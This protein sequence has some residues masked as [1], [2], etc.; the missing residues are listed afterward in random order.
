MKKMILLLLVVSSSVFAQQSEPAK[1]N[2]QNFVLIGSVEDQEKQYNEMLK[3]DP[4]DPAKPA[5]YEEYRAQLALGW[6]TKGNFDRYWYYKNTNPK[7]N[8][9]QLMYL[10][11]AMEHFLDENKHLA[12]LEKVSGGILKDFESGAIKDPIGRAQPIME[13]NAAVNAQLGNIAIAEKMLDQSSK[14]KES[15]R[16]MRYF[17]DT[18]SNYLNRYAIVMS[19]AGK[20]QIAFDTLTKAFRDADSNPAMVNTFRQVYKKVKGSE[21]GFEKYLKSLQDEAYQECYREVTQLYIASPK[22][23]MD[24]FFP[25]PAGKEANPMR[26]F[27]AKQPVT[28]I[29]MMDLN[30]KP[31]KLGDYKGKVLALDF[32]TTLC[33][34]CVAAFSGF[35]RVVADY[36]K[37][38]FQMFVVNL[39]EDQATVKSFVA[40]KGITLDVLQDVENKAYDIQGTPTKIVF[41]P[42]GNIRFYSSGYAGSTDREYYKLKSMVEITKA[43]YKG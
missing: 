7:F 8:V 3:A 42:L 23:T 30:G 17:R 34:P 26:L 20:N 39:F 14:L 32:W 43:K 31:V 9:L 16:E 6:L 11:Y 37:D 18:K 28:D 40:K 27:Q 1:Y 10:T 33:T 5:M 24:G 29:S 12:Q 19:A 4:A 41:D 36:K 21:K 35:D 15:F 38:A 2:F 22:T 25:K 13:V